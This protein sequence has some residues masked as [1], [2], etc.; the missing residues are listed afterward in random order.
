M[1]REEVVCTVTAVLL[2]SVYMSCCIYVK[3]EHLRD[4]RDAF[5]FDV[6]S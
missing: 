2:E 1:W 3:P 6:S 5:D 4:L